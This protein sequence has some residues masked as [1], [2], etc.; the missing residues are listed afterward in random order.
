MKS[1]LKLPEASWRV[2]KRPESILKRTG[3]S[4][5]SPYVPET[6]PQR[7]KRGPQLIWLK[8]ASFCINI[9][10]Q[11]AVFEQPRKFGK[12]YAEVISSCGRICR[13]IHVFTT[14]IAYSE[15]FIEKMQQNRSAT[16]SAVKPR[17]LE[18]EK[19]YRTRARLH[20]LMFSK[21]QTNRD[22]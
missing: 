15:F 22:L 5:A 19:V 1:V 3:A 7:A 14:K 9:H 11:A 18:A 13:R 21:S 12:L 4:M 2:L 10:K 16:L 17:I 20:I 8:V 6:A